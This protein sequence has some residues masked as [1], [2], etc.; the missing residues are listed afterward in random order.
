MRYCLQSEIVWYKFATP[1]SVR[2]LCN[3]FLDSSL[4]S[5]KLLLSVHFGGVY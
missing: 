1:V 2:P 4:K 3:R 5:M